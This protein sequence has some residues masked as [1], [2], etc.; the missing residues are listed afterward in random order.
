MTSVKATFAQSVTAFVAASMI[1]ALPPV[2]E[3]IQSVKVVFVTVLPE[4]KG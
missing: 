3:L 2:V 1:I 4:V